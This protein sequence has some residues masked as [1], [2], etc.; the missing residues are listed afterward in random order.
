MSVD[1]DRGLLFFAGYVNNTVTIV[2]INSGLVLRSIGGLS[3]PQGVAWVPGAGRLYVS[4]AGD[5]TVDIFNGSTFTQTGKITFSGD[6]DNLRYDGGTRLL[7]L[8]YG[9]GGIATINTTSNTVVMTKALPAHPES[10]QV[11]AT[12]QAVY[13][14]VPPSNLITAFDKITGNSILNRSMTG[15]NFPMALDE[16]GARLFVATRSPSELRVLDTSTPS[17]RSVTNVTI[18]G[19]PDDIFF[20]AA[21]GMVYISCGQGSLE[22]IKQVDPTHYNVVQTIATGQG[23][24]TSLLVPELGSIFVGVPATTGQQAEILVF[25]FGSSGASSTSSTGP[26]SSRGPTSTTSVSPLPTSAS[27]SVSPVKGP[28]GLLVTLTGSGYFAGARYQ[29]CVAALGNSSC[30]FEYTS[31]SYP[32]SLGPFEIIGNFTAS[33]AG[34]IPAGTKMAIPDLFG[35]GYSLGVVRDGEL[36]IFASTHFTVES[37]TLSIGKTAVAPK[38][39]VNLTGSGYAPLTTYTVCMVIVGTVDCGYA[40]DREETPPGIYLGT[41]T[42][43]ASGNIPSG[44]KVTIPVVAPSEEAIGIFMPSGGYILISEVQFTLTSAG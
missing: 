41:F 16:S 24:R 14:N 33:L 22:V 44:T 40:G 29:V 25:T 2:D 7:Y 4:N 42:A 35:G 11:E 15:N 38:T 31:A 20:D 3:N 26:N 23:A 10:F 37:P 19:D 27:L 1:L 5:G 8:G 30:G 13:V 21:H 43:D 6:A 39:S 28:T 17:L 32:A 34:N 12:G 9:S 36:A 18:K